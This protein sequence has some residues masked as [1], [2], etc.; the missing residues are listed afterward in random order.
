MRIDSIS[1]PH[2]FLCDSILQERHIRPPAV[3]LGLDTATVADMIALPTV[4]C[5]YSERE[6]VGNRPF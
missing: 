3:L 5:C 4:R 2:A 6:K 1:A